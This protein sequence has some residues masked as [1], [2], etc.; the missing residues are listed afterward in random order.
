MS[1]TENVRTVVSRSKMSLALQ[2][3]FLKLSSSNE[4]VTTDDLIRCASSL[5]RARCC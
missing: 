1:E 5:L 4:V 3:L 2:S